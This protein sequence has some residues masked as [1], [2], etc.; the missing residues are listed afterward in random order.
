MLIALLVATSVYCV[1][2]GSIASN[3]EFWLVTG[4]AAA[5]IPATLGTRAPAAS[6]AHA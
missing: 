1:F 4:V 2:S 6:V 3:A 5:G